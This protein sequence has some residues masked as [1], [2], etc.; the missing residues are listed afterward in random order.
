M[1]REED[2]EVMHNT[3]AETVIDWPLMPGQR[4]S[5]HEE[6]VGLLREMIL[7]S[8]LAP[9]SR[10]AEAGLCRQLG[11]SRTPLREALKVLASEQLVELLP[12]RGAMVSRVTLEE[13]AELFEIIEAFEGLIG[14]L[15]AERMTDAEIAE[16]QDLHWQMLDHHRHGRRSEY[17]QCNQQVHRLLA[18]TTRNSLLINDYVNYSRRIARARYSANS[19]H[20]RW[21]ESVQEHEEFV[22]AAVRRDG[23]ALSHLLRQHLRR[24]A[25][26]VLAAMRAN[27]TARREAP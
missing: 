2:K 5:L 22:A 12:N 16:L 15:A 17:F 1:G 18:R 7:E 10:I 8:R 9:G 19:S 25:D 24:T 26:S 4:P 23:R 6:I 21:D 27:N 13:T 14:E 20:L 11:V 3:G